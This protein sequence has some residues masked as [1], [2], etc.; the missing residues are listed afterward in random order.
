M[1]QWGRP[2]HKGLR[3]NQR[4]RGGGTWGAQDRRLKR[5]LHGRIWRKRGF[6][7]TWT[8]Q[9]NHMNRKPGWQFEWIVGKILLAGLAVMVLSIGGHALILAIIVV[10]AV[11]GWRKAKSWWS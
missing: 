4:I 1:P 10:L 6:M 8:G 5:H 2:A 9:V 3:H 11:L 7:N